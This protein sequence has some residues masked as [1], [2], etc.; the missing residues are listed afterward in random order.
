MQG[1]VPSKQF[2]VYGAITAKI[3]RALKEARGTYQMPWHTGEVPFVVP[4][5]FGPYRDAKPFVVP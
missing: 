5:R 2:N 3:V 4:H 1:D